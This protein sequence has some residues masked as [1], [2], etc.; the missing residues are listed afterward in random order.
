MISVDDLMALPV[1]GKE[2]EVVIAEPH[3]AWKR[4]DTS[5]HGTRTPNRT[6]AITGRA[7]KSM[8]HTVREV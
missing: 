1:L 5:P 7:V 6:V 4:H 2:Q 3:T 8:D